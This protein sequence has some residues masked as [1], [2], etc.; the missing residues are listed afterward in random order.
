MHPTAAQ[1]ATPNVTYPRLATDSAASEAEDY[2]KMFP[3]AAKI[4]F[5]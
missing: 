5:A 4:K 1:R 2:A 3:D